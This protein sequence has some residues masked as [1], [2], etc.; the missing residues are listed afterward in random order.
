MPLA[1]FER[2]VAFP[3]MLDRQVFQIIDPTHMK[4]GSE[5]PALLVS[6]RL[7]FRQGAERYAIGFVD[8]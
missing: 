8:L 6:G 1:R 2:A 4:D 3:A 5:G 7:P